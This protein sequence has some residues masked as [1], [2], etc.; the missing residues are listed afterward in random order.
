MNT[1]CFRAAEADAAAIELNGNG[2]SQRGDAN[3]ADFD[4]GNE[5]HHHEPLIGR[6]ALIVGLH[7][8]GLADRES[9]E[10]CVHE[11]LQLRLSLIK[12]ESFGSQ[13]LSP[14]Q[15]D[16]FSSLKRRVYPQAFQ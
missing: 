8:G 10:S 9:R 11:V 1:V 7:A 6:G 2:V 15:G 14:A 5:A 3:L 4:S 12:A 13:G 16:D